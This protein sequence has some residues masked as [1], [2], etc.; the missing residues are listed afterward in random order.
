MIE[1][2]V[3]DLVVIAG[4]ALALDTGQVLD[5]LDPAAAERALDQARP[6][7]EPGYRPAPPG[8]PALLK[9][10]DT[11][12]TPEIL[13]VLEV[14]GS[15]GAPA[16]VA[17]ALLHALVHHRPFRRGNQQVA[18]AAML[19]FLAVNGWAMDPDPPEPVAAMVAE[20]AAGELDVMAVAASLTP[21]LRPIGDAT[22]QAGEA[23]L[24]QGAAFAER[25]KMAT[26]R[27]QPKGMFQR[28]TD[29]ARRAIY[30]AQEEARLLRHDHVGLEHLLL[31]LLY[32]GEGVAA[33]ALTSLGISLEDIRDQVAEIIGR[34]QGPPRGHI[35]FTPQAKKALEV[36]LRMA[37][38][39]GHN[40]IGTEHVL[41]ALLCAVDGVP[42]QVLGA[43][44]A[45]HAR[46][47]GQVLRLLSSGAGLADPHTR[48]VRVAVPAD[49]VTTAEQLADVRRLKQA[50][51]DAGNLDRAAELR[52][53]EKQLRADK[54]RLEDQLTS[55][56]DMQAVIA[57]NQ[58]VYLELGRLRDLLRQHGIEPDG[59]TAQSA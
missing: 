38:Q 40:Y 45:D 12:D 54:R 9:I 37:L 51:F 28:F 35:P 53:R 8:A 24:R 26:M 25:L 36:S 43:A 58:R 22:A 31:G 46:V 11:S 14:P 56:M 59:G 6:V 19:Q 30:L 27:R 4:R 47:R 2:E 16:V 18:L 39:L 33:T 17:A 23:P 55:G 50:A 3:A 49:L 34:G 10:V 41:L 52:D 48:M 32:E 15:P 57:E 20:V 44:G 13:K 1:L 21:R 29:R 5:L 7:I 42:A